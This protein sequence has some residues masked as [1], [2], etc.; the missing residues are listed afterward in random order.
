MNADLKNLIRLQAVDTSIQELRDKIDAFPAKSK[1][2]DEKLSAAQ[3]AVRKATENIKSSQSR[4]KQLESD[5]ADV[6][7]KISKYKEQLMSV[8]TNA[9]YKAMVKEIEYSQASIGTVEDE[10]LTLMLGS[11]NLDAELKAAEATFKED[12]RTVNAERIRLEEF[13]AQDEKAMGA[14]V[15]EREVLEKNVSDDILSRYDRIRKARSGIA[16]AKASDEACELCNV[17]MRPQ[18]FQEIRKNDTIIACDSCSRILYDPE[19]LDHPF[20]VA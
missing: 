19:N 15:E 3:E 14:Y 12:E 20:E 8:R 17:R 16:V 11:E 1:A 7:V 18:V 10:I 5:I 9:E 4:R 13:T 2:L 6:E